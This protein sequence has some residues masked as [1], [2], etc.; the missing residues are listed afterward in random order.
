M[1]AYWSPMQSV[2]NSQLKNTFRLKFIS[3]LLSL[4]SHVFPTEISP[5][6]CLH[7]VGRHL[8]WFLYVAAHLLRGD[9]L[10]HT[11]GILV[12]LE[13][14]SLSGSQEGQAWGEAAFSCLELL[15]RDHWY[16]HWQWCQPMSAGRQGKANPCVGEQSSAG[17]GGT[18]CHAPG[19]WV[20]DTVL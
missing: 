9:T 1:S 2:Q 5:D 3:S 18:S 11:L 17:M 19:Q 14:R 10:F 7:K 6:F 8:R 12:W 16:F 20:E 4:T 13:F 15:R